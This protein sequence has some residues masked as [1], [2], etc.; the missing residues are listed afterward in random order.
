[1][2]VYRKKEVEVP[3]SVGVPTYDMNP[4]VDMDIPL[5]D[6]KVPLRE[7]IPARKEKV[8]ETSL[9]SEPEVKI[10]AGINIQIPVVD[11]DFIVNVC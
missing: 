8:P 5:P 10:P 9:T 11:R 2:K 3:V 7:Y 1:M 4:S 6:V